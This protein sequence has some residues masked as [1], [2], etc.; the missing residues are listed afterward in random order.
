M[1]GPWDTWWE[2]DSLSSSAPSMVL[3]GDA[4]GT[5]TA[6]GSCGED[7]DRGPLVTLPSSRWTSSLR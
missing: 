1:H 7:E 3:F 5:R 2:G 4:L 6:I